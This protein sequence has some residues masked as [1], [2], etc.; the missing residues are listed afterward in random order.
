MTTV[1]HGL[2]MKPLNVLPEKGRHQHVDKAMY[3]FV[4]GTDTKE[5][6]ITRYPKYLKLEE[7]C[8]SLRIGM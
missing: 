1:L 3:H 8:K 7:T 2:A 6:P 4:A 5:L